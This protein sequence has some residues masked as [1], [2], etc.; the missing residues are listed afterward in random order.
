VDK[1]KQE[2]GFRNPP[3]WIHESAAARF[4]ARS[5]RRDARRRA[6][7]ALIEKLPVKPKKA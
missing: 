6:I 5:T 4:F 3:Q 1:P 7:L 2:P